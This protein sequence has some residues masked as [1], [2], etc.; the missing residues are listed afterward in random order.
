M[1]STFKR[2]QPSGASD[3]INFQTERYPDQKLEDQMRLDTLQTNIDELK[4]SVEKLH[5]KNTYAETIP[6]TETRQP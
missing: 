6:P 1:W 5:S 3:K 2:P 4:T